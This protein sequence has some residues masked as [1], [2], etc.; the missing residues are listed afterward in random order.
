M[1]NIE[2][3]IKEYDGFRYCLN[4]DLKNKN[5]I[6]HHHCYLINENWINRLKNYFNEFY[7]TN[8]F[9]SFP[10]QNP[11]IINCFEEL[12][13]F[14]QKNQ[15]FDLIYRSL[16]DYK[17]RNLKKNEVIC[18]TGNNKII[19]DFNESKSLLIDDPLN[20]NQ[21]KNNS[22]IILNPEINCDLLS[23]R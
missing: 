23:P 17:Y 4:D 20:K 8:T 19:I 12:I 11:K 21:I 6:N 3:L 14:I 16:I 1:K 13:D 18:L 7:N 22:Y 10:S 5:K 9:F 15:K 2:D